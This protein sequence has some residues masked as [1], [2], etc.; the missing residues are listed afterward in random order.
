M[1]LSNFVVSSLNLVTLH[2]Q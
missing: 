2:H 1:P